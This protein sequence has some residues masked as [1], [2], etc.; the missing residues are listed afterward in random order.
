[1]YGHD[2]RSPWASK[3]VT[4]LRG[5]AKPVFI[6]CVVVLAAFNKV[7]RK[8]KAPQG[9]PIELALVVGLRDRAILATL[10]YT[11]CRAGAVAKHHMGDFQHDGEQYVLRFQEK[12]GKS[13]EIPVPLELQRD[14][15]AYREAAGIVA[16]NKE[17]PLFRPTERETKQL[18]GS[19]LTT[20]DTCKLVKRRLNG[21]GMPSRLSRIRPG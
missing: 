2:M 4:E 14:I 10:A 1:M 6:G 11:V 19:A 8:V 9:E 20:K 15:L 21:A 12:G 17:R 5:I 18:T 13:R 16:E 7:S 3:V